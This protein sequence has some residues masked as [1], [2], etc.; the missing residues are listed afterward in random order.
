MESYGGL[1]NDDIASKLITFGGKWAQ[2][3]T[4]CKNIG[5]NL[6][7]GA[8]CRLPHWGALHEPSQQLGIANFFQHGHYRQN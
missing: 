3:I 6:V 1:T 7:K 8:K 4:R 2:H 5:D